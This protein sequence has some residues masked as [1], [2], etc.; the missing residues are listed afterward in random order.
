MDK[1]D[2]TAILAIVIGLAAT[3]NGVATAFAYPDTAPRVWQALF[4]GG[5]FVV[6]AVLLKLLDLHAL[7]G[8]SEALRVT[9]PATGV[10]VFF[11]IVGWSYT[12]TRGET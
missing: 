1:G 4:W 6:L 11:C 7:R 2:Q 9:I 8:A 10:V 5:L 12:G 3:M